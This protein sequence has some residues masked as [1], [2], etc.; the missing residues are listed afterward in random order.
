MNFFVSR[1][2]FLHIDFKN[3]CK[4]ELQD[5]KKYHSADSE[6]SSPEKIDFR[7]VGTHESHPT[8]LELK[9]A[10]NFLQLSL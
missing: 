9:I 6:I 1:I 3:G 4:N 8:A 2:F 7:A 10:N 5:I